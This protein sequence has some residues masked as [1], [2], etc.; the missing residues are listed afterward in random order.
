MISDMDQTNLIKSLIICFIG[1]FIFTTTS[2]A[3]CLPGDSVVTVSNS[4]KTVVRCYYSDTGNLRLVKVHKYRPNRR[5]PHRERE[6]VYDQDG[7]IIS[8]WKDK[9]KT[10]DWGE[11]IEGVHWTFRKNGKMKVRRIK[12]RNRRLL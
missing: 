8:S 5:Y 12:I 7:S 1:T 9:S 4:K 10:G 6:K 3:Q 11:K 2:Q